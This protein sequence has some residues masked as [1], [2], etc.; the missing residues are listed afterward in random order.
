MSEARLVC[1]VLPH[2]TG[3]RLEERL[4]RELG[5]TR[6]DLHSARGFIGSDPRNLF[7]RV[8]RDVLRVVVEEARADEIF[9]WLYREA[10]VGTQEGRFL[11]SAR[12]TQST[13]YR[14]PAGI[15]LEAS[16]PR[17]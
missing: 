17:G 15:P 14:L 1:C 4:F 3:L 7:N 9:E 2:G 8:E 13:E 10:Q 6:V 11:Y 5:M 12:I 16:R